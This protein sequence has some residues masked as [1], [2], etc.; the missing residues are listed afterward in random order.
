MRASLRSVE[1]HAL[2]LPT[3]TLVVCARRY[4]KLSK[5]YPTV[6]CCVGNTFGYSLADID[7][8]AQQS[9]NSKPVKAE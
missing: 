1:R 5:K 4:E 7:V 9:S 6:G 2:V 3:S 8:A